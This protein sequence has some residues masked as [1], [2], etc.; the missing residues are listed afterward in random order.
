MENYIHPAAIK[1][2]LGVDIEITDQCNVPKMISDMIEP[3]EK[4]IK[5]LLNK[6]AVDLM[7]Y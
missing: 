5:H 7:T 2:V 4:T 3:N 6:D 1:V